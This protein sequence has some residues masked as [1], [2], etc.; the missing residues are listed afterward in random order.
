MILI[1]SDYY[2][3]EMMTIEN[4]RKILNNKIKK[5]VNAIN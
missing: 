5:Q 4:I 1:N 3:K 2:D